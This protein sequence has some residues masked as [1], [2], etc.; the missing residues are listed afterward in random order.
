MSESMKRRAALA[1]V[2]VAVSI[3]AGCGPKPPSV[4]LETPA[5]LP[6][7]LG[8]KKL[9]HTPQAY[10]YARDELAAGEMDRM[11]KDVASYVKRKHGRE[12]GKGLVLIMDPKDAPIAATIED[13]LVLERDPS[14]MVTKP[15]HAKSPAEVRNRL[16]DEGIPEGPSILAASVPLPTSKCRE[17]G[18]GGTQAKWAV[19]VP[20]NE[21]A[22]ECAVEITV[23][24]LRKK[25]P[26]LPEEKTRSLARS[27]SLSKPFEVGRSIPI[28]VYWAQSQADWTDGQRIEAIQRFIKYT[29]RSNWLPVPSDDELQ[30]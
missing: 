15:R 17:L 24:A 4:L 3:M 19:A 9:F 30:W 16:V 23:G 2:I 25:R 18:I 5:Q 20:S 6:A 13:Q 26:D 10:I 28:Y 21:L 22:Q 8:E 14:I 29:F 11:V 27:L 7:D 12:L 1:S